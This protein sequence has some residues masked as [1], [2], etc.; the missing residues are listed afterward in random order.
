MKLSVKRVGGICRRVT[1]NRVDL[2]RLKNKD[3][4][5]LTNHCMGGI[6]YHDLGLKFLS[7][8]DQFEAP[9]G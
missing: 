8:T 7:P 1:R 3:F 9:S 4:S 2:L 5:I 6:I